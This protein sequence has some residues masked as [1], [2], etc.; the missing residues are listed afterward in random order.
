[1][2]TKLGNRFKLLNDIQSSNKPALAIIDIDSFKEI[3]DFYGHEIGDNVIVEF[4]KR[5]DDFISDQFTEVYR[6]QADQFAFLY[7]ECSSKESFESRIQELIVE[8]TN[9]PIFFEQ[10]EILL[11]VSVGIS[12]EKKELFINADIALKM[13]KQSKK[14]YVTYT[15]DFNIE[16]EYENNLIWSKKIKK[17]LDE[18]RIV[19]F[20]QPIYNKRT[21]KIEKFEALVRMIEPDE[22][23][24][25]PFFFL[26]ISKKAKL[27]PKITML[28]ID[29]AIKAALSHDYAISLNITI[30]DILNQEVNNYLIQSIQESGVGKKIV[31]ELVE[32]EGIENFEE[33]YSFIKQVKL[34]GCKLAIDD[35][36]TGYSN[37]EYLLKLD[38]DYIK[39]DGSLVKELD[40]N[41]HMRLIAKTIVAFAKTANMK[42]IAEFVSHKEIME[43]VEEIGVDYIQGY[44][45]GKPVPY[46]E[47]SSFKNIS[48]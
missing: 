42:T 33:V 41:E 9:K 19:A 10:H 37:F 36:G 4:S 30:E 35:F 24:I 29:K 18:D 23:I 45:I 28:M 16:Q 26:E 25:S 13:A 3:N 12:F 48:L 15:K 5:L 43:I 1:M 14:N 27:Y 2:L 38:I 46:D 7:R 8:L 44:Y 21:K 22:E 31:I 17:A 34:F 47:I 40:K 11:G 32:S 6:L 20:F 39:I